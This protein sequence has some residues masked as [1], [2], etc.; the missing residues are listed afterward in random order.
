MKKNVIKGLMIGIVFFFVSNSAAQFP[1]FENPLIG[2]KAP[3]FTLDT[4]KSKQ[5]NLTEFREGREAIIFFWATWCPH[6][7]V[8]LAEIQ[9]N[10]NVF[11]SEDVRLLLVDLGEEADVVK[12]FLAD[13]GLDLDIFLDI[14]AKVADEYAL[15]GVPTFYFVNSDGIVIDVKHSFPKDYKN[16]LSGNAVSRGDALTENNA[17]YAK[18]SNFLIFFLIFGLVVIIAFILNQKLVT[19]GDRK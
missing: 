1:M 9:K 19:K 13:E 12:E 8:Q 11:E 2:E 17:K 7:R 16:V 10:L 18:G 4:L 3:D 6:C 15:I 5:V 14:E